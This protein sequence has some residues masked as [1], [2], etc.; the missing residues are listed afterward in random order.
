MSTEAVETQAPK[1]VIHDLAYR[2]YEGVRLS[3]A[4]RFMVIARYALRTQWQLRAV[5]IFLLLALLLAAMGAV[6]VAIQWFFQSM[7]A[8]DAADT[9]AITIALGVQWVPTFLLLV[10]CG[11][12]A[13]A[14]DLNVGAFQFHFARPVSPVQYLAGRFLGAVGFAALFAYGTL[15][16]YCAERV[17]LLGDP[18]TAA[19]QFAVGAFAVTL[20]LIAAGSVA[21]GCS[22]LTRRRGLAQS[23]FAAVVF[24]SWVFAA[25]IASQRHASWI[26]RLSIM[27]ASNAVADQVLGEGPR[28]GVAM[29]APS[30]ALVTFVTAGLGIAWWRVARAEVV[31]G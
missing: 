9:S 24:G 4:T 12:P 7:A 30:L 13:I 20:R 29:I 8:R 2:R 15:A 25:I 22:S 17:A 10:V 28:A 26:A 16:L 23:M 11:A 18:A 27:N 19:K 31:R 3:G 1:G 5:K 14:A 6:G 21:L